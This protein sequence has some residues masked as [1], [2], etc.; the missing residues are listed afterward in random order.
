[1]NILCTLGIQYS[2]DVSSALLFL[3]KGLFVVPGGILLF[4]IDQLF[5]FN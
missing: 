5:I 4:K 3:V 2:T 1:M